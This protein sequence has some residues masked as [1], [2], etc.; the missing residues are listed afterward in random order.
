MCT[1]IPDK[2]PLKQAGGSELGVLRGAKRPKVE[3]IDKQITAEWGNENRCQFVTQNFLNPPNRL[4]LQEV[5]DFI[6][7]YEINS[8]LRIIFCK[9]SCTVFSDL[10]GFDFRWDKQ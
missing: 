4:Y 10:A 8:I 9:K 2:E 3:R 6:Q 5:C 1:F 7:S